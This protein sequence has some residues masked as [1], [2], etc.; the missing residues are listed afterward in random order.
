MINEISNRIK[1]HTEIINS[2]MADKELLNKLELVTKK[3]IDAYKSGGKLVMFGNGGS[4]A[5][6]QH[7]AG[8]LVSKFYLDRP[9]LN[10]LALN[11][12]TSVI[13]SIANDISYDDV[14]ARQVEHLVDYKDVV[15]GISTSGNSKNVIKAVQVAKNK[16]AV[17]VGFT[18]KSGGKLKDYVNILINMPSE[19]TPR[20]QEAH[21]LAGHII[22]ELVEKELF[23]L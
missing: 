15:I 21:I 3:I 12:N 4:A 22:C 6:A 11:V 14:F 23:P 17:V 13:T 8:E 2:I 19:D 9:M 7:I 1:E 18:G 16:G 20:I 10:A 5:D